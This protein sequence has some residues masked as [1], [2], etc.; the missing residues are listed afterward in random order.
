MTTPHRPSLGTALCRV[1][2]AALAA[3]CL[4]VAVARPTATP[5]PLGL[6]AGA[7]QEAERSRRLDDQM[8]VICRCIEE[9][10]RLAREVAAG[11][12][13]LVEAAAR[14]R[15]LATEDPVITPDIFRRAYPG[16]SDE[17]RYCRQVIVFVQ[18]AVRER[19][20]GDLAVVGRLEAELDDL[21]GRGDFRLPAPA[22]AT[23]AAP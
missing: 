23:P 7:D 18:E 12:L 6:P 20:G 5:T 1:F 3:G 19:P 2:L 11:R 9:K 15:D 16:G 21:L 22:P 14:Y 17:E 8:R 4:A 10:E 13:G